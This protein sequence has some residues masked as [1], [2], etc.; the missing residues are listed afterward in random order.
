MALGRTVEELSESMSHREFV[1]WM[2]FSKVQ[3]WGDV[4][5]D[6]R[7]AHQ[8]TLLCRAWG[9]KSSNVKD[10]LFKCTRPLSA[11]QNAEKVNEQNIMALN[12]LFALHRRVDK[13]G[14]I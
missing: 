3:P 1:E 8:T 10:Y 11:R 12:T 7:T 6:W 9:A 14:G 5:A 13:K 2:A 4:R